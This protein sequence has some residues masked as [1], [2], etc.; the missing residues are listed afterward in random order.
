MRARTDPRRSTLPCEDPA[1][2]TGEHA[3]L[4]CPRSLPYLGRAVHA[5]RLSRR[6]PESRGPGATVRDTSFVHTSRTRY[7]KVLHRIKYCHVAGVW[8]FPCR[9]PYLPIG[10]PPAV[11]AS[12][13]LPAPYAGK[14]V[15]L[16]SFAG[17]VGDKPGEITIPFHQGVP[18]RRTPL[19]SARL[20]RLS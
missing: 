11:D 17:V 7:G 2:W 15:V 12:G 3:G 9:V 8:L 19:P 13:S 20:T 5:A 14:T 6:I 10:R 16:P 4:H 18:P 1:G